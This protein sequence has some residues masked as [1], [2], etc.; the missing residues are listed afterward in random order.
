MIMKERYSNE[1]PRLLR[2]LGAWRVNNDSIDFKWGY[3]APKF[4]FQLVLHRGGYFNQRYAITIALGW[5]IFHFYLPIKTSLPEG[6]NMPRYGISIHSDSIWLHIGGNFD[7]E[8][9]QVTS[10]GLVSW[11]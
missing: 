4:S 3:F 7:R 9:G 1:V 2:L 11:S 8:I 5:G 6:C 10:G